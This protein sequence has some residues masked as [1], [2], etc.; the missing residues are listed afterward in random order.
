MVWTDCLLHIAA[1]KKK[2]RDMYMSFAIQCLQESIIGLGGYADEIAIFNKL[3]CDQ[4]IVFESFGELI[5][6][7]LLSKEYYQGKGHKVLGRMKK[8]TNT[9]EPNPEVTNDTYNRSYLIAFTQ[10]VNYENKLYPMPT[11]EFIFVGSYEAALEYARR[12]KR[13]LDMDDTFQ[14]TVFKIKRREM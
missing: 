10:F 11:N 7:G 4:S 3:N 5:H 12:I 13:I 14:K 6:K 2:E 1:T 8:G 9:F